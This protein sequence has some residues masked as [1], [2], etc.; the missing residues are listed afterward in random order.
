[1]LLSTFA[2]HPCRARHVEVLFAANWQK[3]VFESDVHSA[4]IG[5][6]WGETRAGEPKCSAC[7]TWSPAWMDL[8]DRFEDSNE[9]LIASV[10]CNDADA[11][12]LCAQHNVSNAVQVD[13]VG[14]EHRSPTF[15]FFMPPD[16]TGQ[17]WS[18]EGQKPGDL[19]KFAD[20]L[21]GTPSF[22]LARPLFLSASL[23]RP[24]LLM[25]ISSL[26]LLVLLPR[27]Y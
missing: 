14:Q 18:W 13:Q 27:R 10:D 4:F 17:K 20:A 16:V 12:A 5:F 1:M 2:A 26:L 9:I 25:L 15:L 7:D 21:R 6:W 19:V 22:S 8:G 24:R 3:T 11:S 23:P